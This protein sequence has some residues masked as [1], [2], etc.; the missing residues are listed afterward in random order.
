MTTFHLPITYVSTTKSL[1]NHV[2]N[3]LDL[4]NAIGKVL[5]P[6]SVFG[7]R[8]APL[9]SSNFTAN[10]RYL[11]ETQLLLSRKLP[12]LSHDV[13]DI[14]SVWDKVELNSSKT[15]N[16]QNDDL[17]FHA[18]YHYIEWEWLHT[19]N[20]NSRFL[21]YMSVYNMTTP[22]ISL[23]LP[24]IFLI[25]PFFIIRMNGT[26]ISF[27]HYFDILK[28]VFQRHQIGQ[29]FAVSSSTW[30]KRVYITISF[31][32][33]VLQVYQNV[34]RCITFLKNM[35]DIHYQLFIIRDHITASI[36]Y[37]EE[38][39]ECA[40]NMRTYDGF[41][42]NMTR[43]QKALTKMRIEL[44]CITEN[45]LSLSK[46]KQVGHV[47]KCFYQLYNSNEYKQAIEFSFD[48]CGY[49][50]NLNGIQN[51]INTKLLG[52]CKFSK[53]K[54]KFYNAFYPVTEGKPITNTYDI[55]KHHL[56]TGP[57]AAGKTT[58]L[59]TTLFNIVMSQQIGYGCF[60]KAT[61]TPFHHI[62]CYINIPDTNGR[63]SLFQAEARRCKDILHSVESEASTERHFCV[64][65]ELYSGTNPYEAIGSAT[66]YLKYLD[67]YD[68]I[69]FMI[70]T[71]F[72]HICNQLKNETRFR[73]CHMKVYENGND[74]KYTYKL[75][76]GISQTK[77]GVKVL[78][79]L[80]YP[81]NL[82]ETTKNIITEL[83]S[84]VAI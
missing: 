20:N 42:E 27:A 36:N 32:F 31:I 45:C 60:S 52:K 44:D 26:T 22:V 8:T 29:L 55:K 30:D 70:T 34:R 74:F 64:F 82:I 37:M 54:T 78:R 33:Y 9:W 56:I 17:G 25:I 76:D 83:T 16:K 40:N 7:Q 43:H 19:L 23:A 61:L 41:I 65:D 18:R 21:Q 2:I 80:D 15:T 62:H 84:E 57:N 71:H 5:N 49:I 58:L 11:K 39:K 13:S 66:A 77:G 35:R 79:D 28:I 75:A 12:E 72:L 38:F 63:D 50:D 73:N 59:K 67:R 6:S 47:M 24:I 69:S 3:D 48:F 1:Q 4:S 10:T 46:M 53:K 81:S 51:S 68:N 14:T